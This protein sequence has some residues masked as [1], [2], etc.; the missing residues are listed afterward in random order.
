MVASTPPQVRSPRFFG[1]LR[2]FQRDAPAMLARLAQEHGDVVHLH[3]RGQDIYFLN[4]PDL[5]RDVLVTHQIKFKK[6]RI[7]ERARVLLGNGLLTS[8]GEFHKRQRRL[9]QPAFHRERLAGYGAAMVACAARC[10]DCWQAGEAFDVAREMSRLT[11]AIVGQTLF[12]ADVEAQADDVG[13]ALTE[14]LDLF[15]LM[16]LPFSEVLM[17]LPLPAA[18][19]F[20]RARARLDSVVYGLIAERRASGEDKGDLLSMLLLASDEEASAGEDRRM[21]DQQVR[22]EAMTLFLAGHETTA[23]AMSWCWYLLSQNP[24]AESRLHAELDAVLAGRLPQVEDLLQLPYATHVF[25][26]T[27]RLYPPAWGIGR[28]ALKDFQAGPYTVPKGSIVLTSPWVMHRDPRF[29][30]DPLVFRPERWEQEDPARPKFAYFPFGG[31]TRVCIGERFAWME[32]VLLL[33]VLAQRWKL[34]LIEGHP[35]ETQAR[36]TLRPKFGMQMTAELR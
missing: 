11:L 36:I 20:R 32:G 17:R 34:R 28:K 23:N 15:Q 10:R 7:L 30:P 3:L 6:S 31:G 27:L 8:E 29:F 19:R 1:V 35:V 14:V 18:R 13:A 33:A 24:Q 25:A 26:E 9:V 5:V 4:H 21:T 12:S 2:E 16:L 22:D